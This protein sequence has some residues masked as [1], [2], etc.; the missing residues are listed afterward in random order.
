MEQS[1]ISK[2][3]QQI[4]ITK[5]VD[6]TINIMKSNEYE[7]S[8]QT[9]NYIPKHYKKIKKVSHCTQMKISKTH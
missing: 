7:Y 5:L 8:K 1:N 4:K 2:L 9:N 6:S 3:H